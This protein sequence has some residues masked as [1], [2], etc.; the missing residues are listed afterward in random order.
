MASTSPFFSSSTALREAILLRGHHTARWATR[1]SGAGIPRWLREGAQ[2]TVP[3]PVPVPFPWREWPRR[4]AYPVFISCSL[5]VNHWINIKRP[6]SIG[7]V[8]RSLGL[9]V[10]LGSFLQVGRDGQWYYISFIITKLYYW[11]VT[12]KRNY[13]KCTNILFLN[14]P[15]LLGCNVGVSRIF[16]HIWYFLSFKWF[17]TC[18]INAIPSWTM[19]TSN[20][21]GKIAQKI[22]LGSYVPF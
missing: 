6:G 8:A 12:C 18:P 5:E 2:V 4:L 14:T 15:I 1:P 3:P 19:C 20:K 11:D 17:Y 22:Y 13:L 21:F 7:R 9:K 10:Y 16:G